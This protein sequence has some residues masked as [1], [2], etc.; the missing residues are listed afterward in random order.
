MAA[1]TFDTLRFAEAL[2][3]SG[4]DDGQA[5]GMAEA[6]REVQTMQQDDWVTKRDVDVKLAEM[7]I[8]WIKWMLA[9]LAGQGTLVVLAI[10][11]LG[12]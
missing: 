12:Q 4:F 1:V 5:K 6:L 3:A 2:K 7:E 9:M 8:R 10:K 11:L